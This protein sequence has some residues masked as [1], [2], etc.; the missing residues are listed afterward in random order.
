MIFCEP[1]LERHW[2]EFCEA[3]EL[4]RA[5]AD[6]ALAA[7]TTRAFLDPHMARR[8]RDAWLKRFEERG[9]KFAHGP[10]NTMEEATA[11][12]QARENDYITDLD[13]PTLGPGQTL[14]FPMSFSASE[15]SIRRPACEFGEHTEE[16]LL[17]SCDAS[18]DEIADLRMRG[19][20]A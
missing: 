6:A 7:G 11:M 18:W 20:I 2:P 17:D 1:Q 10:V 13:H 12:L 3:L 14:G 16:I 15:C 4:D 9:C 8:P 5:A 19:V